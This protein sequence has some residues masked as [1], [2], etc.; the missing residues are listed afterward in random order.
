MMFLPVI[1][2]AAAALAAAAQ[3]A[4]EVPSPIVANADGSW[5]IIRDIEEPPVSLA[6]LTRGLIEAEEAIEAETWNSERE[7]MRDAEADEMIQQ[8]FEEAIDAARSEP[9]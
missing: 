9:R 7:R 1:A 5:T 4:A 3:P 8:A 6:Q 2:A